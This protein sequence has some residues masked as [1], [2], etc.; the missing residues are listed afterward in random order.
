M[1]RDADRRDKHLTSTH[2]G[3]PWTTEKLEILERYLDAYTTALKEQPFRLTYV[4]AF[5]GSGYW[6]PNSIYHRDDYG[7]F[8]GVLKGSARIALGIQDKP[9]D[10][11][12]FI[13]KY[14]RRYKSLQT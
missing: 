12:V 4:D 3:G 13:E 2:F 6:R 9:F 11:L 1:A 8:E 5:A 7:D 14:P 10:D